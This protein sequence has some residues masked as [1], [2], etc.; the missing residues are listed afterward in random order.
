MARCARSGRTAWALAAACALSSLAVARADVESDAT[1]L[2]LQGRYAQAYLLL[3]K[4]QVEQSRSGQR[5]YLHAVACYQTLQLAEARRF[6]MS[7]AARGYRLPGAG[8]WSAEEIV[9]RV[10]RVSPLVASEAVWTGERG[11]PL[12]RAYLSTEGAFAD[13]VRAAATRAHAAAS[14]IGFGNGGPP[15]GVPPIALYL[16]PTNRHADYFLK[17]LGQRALPD[18]AALSLGLGVLMWDKRDGAPSYQ[19]PYS[20]VATLAHETL[21]AF[22]S[23]LGLEYGPRWTIEGTAMLAEDEVDPNHALLTRASALERLARNPAAL[24][25]ALQHGETGPYADYPLYHVLAGYLRDAY[26]LVELG[27]AMRDLN[28]YEGLPLARVLGAHFGMTPGALC[29][30][31][32]AAM[33]GEGWEAARDL[34]LTREAARGLGA[35]ERA[36]LWREAARRHRA[37][38]YFALMA[39]LAAAEAGQRHSALRLAADLSE[40][41]YLGAR[42]GTVAELMAGLAGGFEAAGSGR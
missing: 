8:W 3:R 9:D 21:H 34:V 6:A 31:A 15:E 20:L 25:G 10:R 12:Y 1:G 22:Q 7:A 36:G 26:G 29:D 19:G 30:M 13:R 2:M 40:A 42:E 41:G 39:A 38:P 37:E 17:V 27:S 11:E 32:A 5:H 24:G 28:R 16:F 18:G 35:E 14:R 4:S 33:Q 23:L